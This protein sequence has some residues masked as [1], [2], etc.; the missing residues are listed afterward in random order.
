MQMR[1]GL[2]GGVPATRWIWVLYGLIQAVLAMLLAFDVIES[3]TPS[4]VVTGVALI[5]YVAVNEV[6]GGRARAD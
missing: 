5:L 4:A 6:L 3:T 2:V 1:R